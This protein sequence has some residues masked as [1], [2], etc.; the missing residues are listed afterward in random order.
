MAN[1]TVD[2]GKVVT[3]EAMFRF[4]RSK[5][6]TVPII[7]LET[8]PRPE[9]HLTYPSRVMVAERYDAIMVSY[10]D[11]M[12]GEEHS[13]D[14]DVWRDNTDFEN[15]HPP[16]PI[17]RKIAYTTIRALFGLIRREECGEREHEE[18]DAPGVYNRE[19]VEAKL[20]SPM[21]EPI[22][23]Q[24][25]L[26][27]YEV[28]DP[29]VMYIAK[30]MAQSHLENEPRPRVISGNWTLYEDRPGKAG[31]TS[32]KNG[33]V[34]EFDVTF[35][36]RGKLVVGILVSYE[37]VGDALL[38]FPESHPE[39]KAILSG[40][41]TEHTSITVPKYLLV[42][43]TYTEMGADRERGNNGWDLEPNKSYRMRIETLS[44]EKFKILY[45][46]ST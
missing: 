3:T 22:A 12:G 40:K 6:P 44:D 5:Y 7:Y 26:D 25:Q 11:A 42:T 29:K 23:D 15:F 28:S 33:S 36:N 19:E 45:V 16:Y 30:N 43:N 1:A 27:N 24:K 9:N 20:I 8:L 2:F 17:H 34:I 46:V 10:R 32:E 39:G 35:G 31:W 4:L 13:Y 21:P 14:P 41:H 38:Y 18:I 37:K